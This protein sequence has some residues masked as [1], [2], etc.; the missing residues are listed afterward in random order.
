MNLGLLEVDKNDIITLAN[1]SFID[2]SGYSFNDLIGHKASEVFLS[3]ESK[4]VVH[5]KNKNRTKGIS[6]SYEIKVFN[7]KREPKQWLVSGAPNYDINGKV[8]GSIGIHLDITEQKEQE[9]Q[10]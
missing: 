9:A 7:K 4:K 3:E 8:I 1:Q 10:L 2:M 6:D 5:S